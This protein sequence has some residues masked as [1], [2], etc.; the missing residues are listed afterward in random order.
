[1]KANQDYW[2]KMLPI[3]QAFV[4]GKAVWFAGKRLK[5]DDDVCFWNSSDSYEVRPEPVTRVRPF[6]EE[7][8]MALAPALNW[9]RAKSG[10]ALFKIDCVNPREQEKQVLVHQVWYAIEELERYLVIVNPDG[11]ESPFGVVEVVE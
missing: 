1:M 11:S 10:P 7:E 3:I 6:T 8:F 2:K 9:V 4:D 5:S